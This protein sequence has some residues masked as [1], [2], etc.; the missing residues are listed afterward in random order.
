MSECFPRTAQAGLIFVAS[1]VAMTHSDLVPINHF[2]L[3][4]IATS[5]ASM[6]IS[7]ILI[8]QLLVGPLGWIFDPAAETLLKPAI[9]EEIAAVADAPEPEAVIEAPSIPEPHIKSHASPA[10]KRRST[11]RDLDAS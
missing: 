2:G 1:F 3:M 11:K 9:V 8:S 5:A 10:K 4:I 7:P 6:F